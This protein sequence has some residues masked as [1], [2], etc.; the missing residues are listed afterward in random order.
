LRYERKLCGVA[1]T[2]TLG[3][4]NLA[5]KRYWRESPTQFGHVYLYPGAPRTLRLSM[6]AA[7]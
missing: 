5:D 4:E 6:T 2:W 1:T 3:I 7:L